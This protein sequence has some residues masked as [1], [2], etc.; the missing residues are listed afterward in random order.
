MRH[1]A[2]V[3]LIFAGLAV[4]ACS[5]VSEPV[6]YTSPV[7]TSAARISVPVATVALREV[8]LPSYASEEGIAVADADGA[9]TLATDGIWADEPTRA[10]TLRLANAL[11]DVTGRVVAAD[12]W[13]FREDPDAVLEVRVEQFV[14]EASGQFVA[15]GR[16]YVVRTDSD[17]DGRALSFSFAEPY[18]PDGGFAGIAAARSRVV[19]ALARDIARRGLR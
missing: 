14:A 1:L 4:G 7:Q 16:F 19:S 5:E 10:V 6:R 13:P 17:R 2:L 11:S 9:I 18:D 12:P 8:S 3:S 15:S